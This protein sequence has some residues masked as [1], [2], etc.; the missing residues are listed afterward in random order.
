MNLAFN[1]AVGA[2]YTNLSQRMRVI[3][4]TWAC[5]NAYCP[6]CGAPSLRKFGNNKPV[7][8]FFC[9][10]CD[11]N[12]ELKSKKERA[13]LGR[14]PDGAYETA[15]KRIESAKNPNLFVIEYDA[16]ET[17]VNFIVTP[18]FFFTPAV[19]RKRRPLG[20]TARRAGWIGSDILF[21]EIPE[22][23]KI[24]IVRDSRV[25]DRADVLAAFERSRRLQIND[26]EKRG[27]TFDVLNC[28]NA[29]DADVFRLTDVYTFV[30]RLQAAHP[31][32]RN[33][34]AKIRQQLQILRDK[35]FLEFLERGVYRKLR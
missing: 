18:K 8:D 29:I 15:I 16:A 28:V 34:E 20:P 22:Q 30:D 9:A 31:N 25:V 6:C 3:S 32:N 21:S 1:P 19:V 35:G 5:E 10:F 11:E 23:G 33:V 12:F 17:V 2:N 26:L 24:D 27:W 7:A 4:E 14:I 13:G